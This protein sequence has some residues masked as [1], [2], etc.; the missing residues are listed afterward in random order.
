LYTERFHELAWKVPGVDTGLQLEYIIK[1]PVEYVANFMMFM[2]D[3]FSYIVQ[4]SIVDLVYNGKIGDYWFIIIYS[5][6]IVSAVVDNEMEIRIDKWGRLIM[7]FVF[8]CCSGLIYSALFLSFT[9][10]GSN[11]AD[12][13]QPRYFIPIFMLL[14]MCLKNNA[15]SL[16][17]PVKTKKYLNIVIAVV[18][19][20]SVLE[21]AKLILLNY[22]L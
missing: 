2:F 19:S 14:F 22:Y 17:N 13:I 1:N 4:N 20:L 15:I 3:K 16:K 12:G 7:V 8:L 9:V 18:M 5:L 11:A 21:A 6:L 10:V